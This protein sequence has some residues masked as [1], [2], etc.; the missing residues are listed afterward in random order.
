MGNIT[1]FSGFYTI[2]RDKRKIVGFLNIPYFKN[3]EQVNQQSLSLLTLLVN[4]YVFIFLAIGI[5]AVLIS[6][7]IIR[8][9]GILSRKIVD[10]NL[11][12]TNEPIEWATRD[13]IGEIIAA[14][15]QMLLKLAVSEEKL[16]LRERESAWQE[17]ARQV[18]HE[19]KNP[20]TP[21]RLSVQHLVRTWSG[22]KPENDRLNRMFEKVTKTILIQIESLVNIADSFSQFSKMPAPKNTVFLLRSVVEEVAELYSHSDE[23][24]LNLHVDEAEFY[25]HSDRD[26]LSRVFNNLIKNAKQ[27]IDHEEG[28]VE[29]RLEFDGNR[30]VVSVTD[31]GKGIPDEIGKRVF[32]PK[33]STKTSGMGLGLAMGKKIVEGSGGRIYFE[34]E[35]GTGTTFYVELRRA[36]AQSQPDA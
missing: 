22:D 24:Q 21:M 18:A 9:L 16:A 31:N 29:V 4:I 12:R 14:Y 27:A 32:E 33:F 6:N 23:V 19:I 17:M 8:P 7:S 20:L 30:A 28:K 13:E 1:F 25:V 3:Q 34:T 35:V 15:N 36:E 5:I 26:Q 10:T 2:L 11:G